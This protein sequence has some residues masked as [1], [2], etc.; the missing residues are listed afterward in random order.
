[1]IDFMVRNKIEKLL[2]NTSLVLLIT[3]VFYKLIEPYKPRGMLNSQLT[4]S[5]FVF[6]VIV[7]A[8]IKI[9]ENNKPDREKVHVL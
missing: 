2:I 9:A 7:L 3:F 1:M 4:M 5:S 8:F 6:A